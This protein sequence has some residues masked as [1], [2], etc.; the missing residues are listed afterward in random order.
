MPERRRTPLNVVGPFYVEAH[1][2]M[3]CGAPEAEAPDLIRFDETHGSCYFYR[4]PV[5]PDETFRAIRA[6]CACCVEA[7]R[8]S[9]ADPA[10]LSRLARLRSATQC[11]TPPP[12]PTEGLPRIVTF[13][14]ATRPSGDT[15]HA[16][17][18]LEAI[19]VATKASTPRL[20]VSPVVVH[21]SGRVAF[22]YTWAPTVSGVHVGLAPSKDGSGRWALFTNQPDQRAITALCDLH[23]ALV[24]VPEISGIRWYT[25]REWTSSWRRWLGRRRWQQ[26]PF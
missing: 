20:E 25:D 24:A 21:R 23:D 15:G 2:C 26:F 4:Q 6:V 5:G 18:I 3:S 19:A 22:H 11:D 9:G 12:P 7:V 16:R 10:I 8:Y 1:Q 13:T 14:H 17:S